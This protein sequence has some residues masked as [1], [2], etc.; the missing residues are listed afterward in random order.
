MH[1]KAA[2]QVPAQ[3]PGERPMSCAAR[4]TLLSA[5]GGAGSEKGHDRK[6]ARRQQP[7]KPPGAP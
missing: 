1:R 2:E 5:T 7:A 4:L 6:I 3:Q